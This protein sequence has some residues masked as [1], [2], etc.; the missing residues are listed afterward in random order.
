MAAFVPTHKNDDTDFKPAG[1]CCISF[2]KHYI[3]NI[4]MNF[5]GFFLHAVYF[6]LYHLSGKEIHVTSLIDVCVES[7]ML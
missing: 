2:S 3:E 6:R 4:G 5:K 7:L 1:R